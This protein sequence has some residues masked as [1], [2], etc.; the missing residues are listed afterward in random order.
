MSKKI[1]LRAG[2]LLTIFGLMALFQFME[3]QVDGAWGT[4]VTGLIAAIGGGASV[5]YEKD[6]WNLKK[7][8]V[9]HFLVM[10]LTV[11]PILLVSGWFELQEF[12]DYIIVLVIFLGV[13]L[14]AWIFFIVLF[15]FLEKNKEHTKK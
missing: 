13:G 3:N 8:S 14:V 12:T 4:M 5:I 6:Q 7:Q 11:Y 2:I 9:I 10:L 1:L 15:H